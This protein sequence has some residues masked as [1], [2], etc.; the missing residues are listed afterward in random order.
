MQAIFFNSNWTFK[1]AVLNME[2]IKPKIIGIITSFYYCDIKK[3]VEFK[4]KIRNNIYSF[5]FERW[6][7]D[8][9]VEYIYGDVDYE[10][11][12]SLVIK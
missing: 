4:R 5:K 8:K 11:L 3:C 10:S 1:E 9:L 2:E 12:K 7:C 6:K